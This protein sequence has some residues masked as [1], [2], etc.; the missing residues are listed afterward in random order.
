[1]SPGEDLSLTLG[2]LEIDSDGAGDA[3]S[4]SVQFQPTEGEAVEVGTVE[5]AADGETADL[6]TLQAPEVTGTGELVMT[7][8]YD[9]QYESTTEV[10]SALTI[11]AGV[12]EN[13]TDNEPGSRHFAPV[14][15][16]QLEGLTNGYSDGS[17]GKDR[18]ISR[19]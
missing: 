4:V 19:G 14:R 12:P 8:S 6:S 3:T 1:L 18:D 13:F 5:V 7:V 11:D 16:M 10:R 15:W 2:N 9:D 17:F